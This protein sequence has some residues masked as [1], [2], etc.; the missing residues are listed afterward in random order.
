MR[1]LA[2]LLAAVMLLC[3]GCARSVPETASMEASSSGAIS[4]GSFSES[5][6]A[7]AP[8]PEPESIPKLESETEPPK[9]EPEQEPV[10]P[11]DGRIIC[12]D[13]G[14]CITPL[15]SKGYKQPVS[16]LSDEQKSM[17]G[18]GTQGAHLSEVELN[19]IVGLKLRDA[20]EALGAEVVMTREVSELTISL[21]ERC[22]IADKAGADVKVSIHADG[23]NDHSLHGVSVLVPAAELLGTPEI[24]EESVRLGEL[25]VDAVA[26]ETGAHNRGTKARKDLTGF[27]FST[28]PTVLIEMG[29]MTNPEEETLLATEE[30]QDKIVTG[31]VNSLLEWYGAD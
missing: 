6:P 31:M 20:L 17:Y 21:I 12:V 24:R 25:M 23:N 26:E 8:E 19:L 3:S 28:V 14:H 22:E 10:L 9:P 18:R 1:I 30:Y 27:N 15:V 2:G 29:F 7:L 11:L 4:S 16:P 5:G 13:P